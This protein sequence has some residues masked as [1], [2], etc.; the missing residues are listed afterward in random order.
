VSRPE[1]TAAE[2]GEK[3]GSGESFRLEEAS[4]ISDVNIQDWASAPQEVEQIETSLSSRIVIS[5]RFYYFLFIRSAS[6]KSDVLR[7]VPA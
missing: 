7:A 5:V 3:S 6:Q 4:S 2:A 1:Q